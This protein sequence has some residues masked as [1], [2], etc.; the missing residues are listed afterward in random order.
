MLCVYVCVMKDLY[1]W[2]RRYVCLLLSCQENV[3]GGSFRNKKEKE[4]G[5]IMCD[6][7]I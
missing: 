5:Y 3:L 6:M 1:L 2:R 7:V 4:D